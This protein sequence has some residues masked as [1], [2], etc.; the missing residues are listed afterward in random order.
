MDYVEIKYRIALF[1]LKGIGPKN[2]R[3][4]ISDFGSARQFFEL[5]FSIRN[6]SERKKKKYHF[7]HA[8]ISQ[9]LDRAEREIE[10][11]QKHDLK[12]FLHDGPDFPYRLK[13]CRSA[14]FILYYKGTANLNHPRIL[15]IVGTRKPSSEG[16]IVCESVVEAL[17]DL[18]VLVVSGLAYGIDHIA[19]KQ[20]ISH[21][22]NTIGVLAHGLDNL[23]PSSHK[24]LAK[25]M[26]QQGG[27]LT[28]F[29]SET[30]PDRE[31]FPTRNAVVAG[32][33]DAVLVV[34]SA[35]KGG[36]M[37]TV[38]FANEYS[39]D[40]F[41]IPGRINDPLSA[42]C[43]HLIKSHQANLYESVADL[44]YIMGWDASPT[45]NLLQQ[46]LFS[47]LDPDEREVLD[48]FQSNNN[49][50]VDELSQSSQLKPSKLSAMLLSLEFKGLIR[51]LPGKHYQSN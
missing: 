8:E 47:S 3:E 33:C 7:E 9:A 1:L 25:Q 19:H 35:K 28:R 43:N 45:K 17:A 39:R 29:M 4:I 27:L 5:N 15:G 49:I 50:H 13:D 36:S 30:K 14:P 18:D 48:L 37:I 26:S 38:S 23:Y 51:T 12:V 46:E 11:I 32:I 40:V 31:N 16:K 22:L 20:S 10:F 42:G 44:K 21:G 24:N 2:G 6:P 34:E 41:A